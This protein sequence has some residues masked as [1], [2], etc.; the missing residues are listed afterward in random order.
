MPVSCR[1]LC[2]ATR[3]QQMESE[4][5]SKKGS[6]KSVSFTVTIVTHLTLPLL[7]TYARQRTCRQLLL[8]HVFNTCCVGRWQMSH[9]DWSF[10]L[11]QPSME[12][13]FKETDWWCVMLGLQNLNNYCWPCVCMQ[14]QTVNI[15]AGSYVKKDQFDSTSRSAFFFLFFF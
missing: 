1:H 5:F 12:V 13:Q 11:L 2:T 7:P 10:I 6:P 9:L 14:P 8:W 15:T 4:V 3:G